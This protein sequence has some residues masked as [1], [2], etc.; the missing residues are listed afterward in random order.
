M[1][2]GDIAAGLA[3]SRAAGWN[4][5]QADWELFLKL[6][7]KGC[8]VAVDDEGRVRGTVATVR[9]QDHFSWIGMVLVDAAMQRRGI[10][11]QLLREALHILRNEG[12]IKLDATPAGRKIYVQLDFVDEYALSRMECA[13]VSLSAFNTSADVRPITDDDIP[14]LLAFDRN[15]F[16]A[17]RAAL[18][19][20]VRSRAPQLAFLNEEAG[21]LAGYCMG[22]VGDRFTHIGPV[23]ANDI[24]VAQ[25]VCGAALHQAAGRPLIID[26]LSDKHRW[27]AWLRE[28][29][30][31]EQ[32]PLIRMYRGLNT[33][34]GLIEN[35]FGILGP[36]FG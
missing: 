15:V 23:V 3:L 14:R 7:P 6:S 13:D 12:T 4:Q 11:I 19:E 8:A 22:R 16:G 5:T 27:T 2:R 18:L 21:V 10:G 17:D 24:R 36:E 1:V 28:I 25:K 20:S 26:A 35:Q 30:F 29:G 34:P 9:Y 33:S 31:R 32:R